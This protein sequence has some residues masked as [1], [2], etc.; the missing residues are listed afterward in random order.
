MRARQGMEHWKRKYHTT[1]VLLS[2][3][4]ELATQMLIVSRKLQ[5]QSQDM[6]IVVV[7]Q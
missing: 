4:I 6:T 7:L 2:R 5:Q 1:V 3:T